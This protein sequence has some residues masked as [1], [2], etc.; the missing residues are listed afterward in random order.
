MWRLRLQVEALT[1]AVAEQHEE[2][3]QKDE[4]MA[5][6]RCMI[7]TRTPVLDR[8][9][10][11]Q[12]THHLLDLCCTRVKHEERM[13]SEQAA[14]EQAMAEAQQHAEEQHQAHAVA[15]QQIQAMSTQ[16]SDAEQQTQATQEKLQAT[17]SKKQAS[18]QGLRGE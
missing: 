8:G 15:L 10:C 17:N 16:I 12:V 1:R 4:Q 5:A 3:M 7:F 14:H 9:H 2:Q 11:S 18:E 13:A 6:L